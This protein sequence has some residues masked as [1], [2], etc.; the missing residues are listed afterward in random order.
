MNEKTLAAVALSNRDFPSFEAKLAEAVR[1]IE[2]AA[3]QGADLVVLPETINYFRGDGPDNGNRL[4]AEEAALDDWKSVT[5]PLFDVARS[6]AVALTIPVLTREGDHYVNSFFLVSKTGAVIGQYQKIRVTPGELKDGVKPGRFSLME[7]EGL[8][9]GG[10]ICFDCYFPE[11]F[12]QQA[13]AGADLFLVPS[14]T[15]GG[16]H[17][18][19][20]ALNYS[21]PI[22]LAYPAWSRI[23]DVDGREL[24]AGGYRSETLRFGFGA[25]VIMAT[26]N[27]DRVVLHIDFNQSRMV[28]IQR[29]YGERV[30]V[31][32]N[33]HNSIFIL[34]SRSPDLTVREIMERF[35]LVSKRVYLRPFSNPAQDL[36]R[37]A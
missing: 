23:I 10:G 28:D 30:R 37:D 5:R 33:Q 26:I 35:D 25:P 34:E 1:W 3:N 8:K 12:H 29:T 11:V 6:C 22:V 32:L 2:L 18:N 24:A 31:T 16:D 27:F 9:V 19:F 20:Y 14:L 21:T 36:R 17:L 7:W 4:T 15:P 13:E